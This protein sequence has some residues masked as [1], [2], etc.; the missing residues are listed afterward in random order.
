MLSE[1]S[2]IWILHFSEENE[3][4]L[5]VSYLHNFELSF[6]SPQIY[7]KTNK[8]FAKRDQIKKIKTI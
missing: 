7:Q 5:K 8:Y 2:D 6:W 3:R 1:F 4:T